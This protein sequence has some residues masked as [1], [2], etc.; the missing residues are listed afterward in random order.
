MGKVQDPEEL[1]QELSASLTRALGLRE[2]LQTLWEELEEVAQKGRARRAQSTELNSDLC[3]AHSV[4]V[5]AFRG[6]HRKQEEQRRKL[7]QQVA[8]M[9]TRQAEELAALEATARA[10]GRARRPC[11]PPRPGET[12]LLAL[13]CPC[14]DMPN[15]CGRS[16][17][18]LSRS[19]IMSWGMTLHVEAYLEGCGLM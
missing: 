7:E 9:E 6:A 14:L 11:H 10:L 3:Q 15:S 12:F 19:D 2:Q 13:L 16:C 4:L 1:A 8:L 5:L 17:H 18:K